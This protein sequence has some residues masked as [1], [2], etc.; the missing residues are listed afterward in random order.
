MLDIVSQ[1]ENRLGQSLEFCFQFA[2]Y[3]IIIG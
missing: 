1:I 3:S 2:D